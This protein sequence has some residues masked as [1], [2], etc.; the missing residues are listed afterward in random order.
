MELLIIGIDGGDERIIRGMDM[1]FLQSL[2]EKSHSRKLTEDI[3]SRGWAEIMTGL[4][5]SLIHI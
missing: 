3:Y 1:P 5:L 4:T 2:I